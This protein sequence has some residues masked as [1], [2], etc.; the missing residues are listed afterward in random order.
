[1]S[2]ACEEEEEE[3]KTSSVD[4]NQFYLGFS[5]KLI[6]KYTVE[7]TKHKQW[8]KHY[9]KMTIMKIWYRLLRVCRCVYTH[10]I[11]NKQNTVFPVRR[12]NI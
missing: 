3:E 11:S 2:S 10:I 4:V 9:I 1:M 7:Q 8:I 6:L 5:H 12:E